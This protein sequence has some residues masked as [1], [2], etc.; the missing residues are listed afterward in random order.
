MDQILDELKEYSI[1]KTG[2]YQNEIPLEIQ[3]SCND[4]TNTLTIQDTGYVMTKEELIF[5]CQY[6]ILYLYLIH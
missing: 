5:S 6:P 2:F 1:G 3:I 4:I